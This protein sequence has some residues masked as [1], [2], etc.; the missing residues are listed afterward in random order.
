MAT[1]QDSAIPLE[2]G[3]VPTIGNFLT[4]YF[5]RRSLEKKL[6]CDE[7]DYTLKEWKALRQ[8][9]REA[10]GST[11]RWYELAEERVDA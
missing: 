8:K 4:N 3:D 9:Y 10:G 2:L 11:E 6:W 7:S 1:Q 5:L